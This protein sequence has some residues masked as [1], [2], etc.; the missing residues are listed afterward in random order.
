[1][2]FVGE[3]E[4]PKEKKGEPG[5]PP[6]S[7]PLRSMVSMKGT[8]SFEAWVDELVEITGSGTRSQCLKNGLKSLAKEHGFKK[9]MPKR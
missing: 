2:G 5:R 4:M 9:P 7:E 6:E 8:A 1:M 3:L